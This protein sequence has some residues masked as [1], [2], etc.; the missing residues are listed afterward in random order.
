MGIT[1]VSVWKCD[2][3]DKETQVPSNTTK[4]QGWVQIS[5]AD[6]YLD[7]SWTEKC[8]CD[9]CMLLIIRR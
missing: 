2:L 6:K 7:R 3:C 4:P 5:I 9:E 8:I 1:P